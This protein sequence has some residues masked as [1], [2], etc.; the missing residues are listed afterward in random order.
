MF[1]KKKGI[2][3]AITDKRGLS[4]E[5]FY[6]QIDAMC[7]SGIDI[8]QLREKTGSTKEMLEIARR[9]GAI[10]K[11]HGVPYVIDDRVDICLAADADGVH[12][13]A[14]DLPVAMAREILGKDKIIGATAKTVEAAMQ[15][16]VDG[17]DYLGVGAIYDTTTHDNPVRTSVET[18]AQIVQHVNIPVY[19]IGGLRADN[20]S[21]LKGSGA[22]GVCVVRYLMQSEDAQSDVEALR[23]AMQDFAD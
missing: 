2:V 18:L 7:Q 8:L 3:Y 17:A 5:T 16:E 23:V 15:A 9:V 20:V 22:H 1:D 21:I 13:G 11:K 19:A 10:A 14:D 12:L 6:Q 4:E